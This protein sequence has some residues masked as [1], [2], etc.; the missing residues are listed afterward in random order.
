[1]VNIV[2]MILSIATIS[3]NG[4]AKDLGIYSTFH[5]HSSIVMKEANSNSAVVHKT[6]VN[7]YKTFIRH[8]ASNWNNY[9][10]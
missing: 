9:G 2:L 8:V 10:N 5:N 6:F 1:M 3:S 4:V 7:S